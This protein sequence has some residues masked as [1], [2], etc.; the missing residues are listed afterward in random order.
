MSHQRNEQKT[1]SAPKKTGFLIGFAAALIIVVI[2][3]FTVQITVHPP[4][5]TRLVLDRTLE[6]YVAPPCFNQAEVT[7]N[8]VDSTLDTANRLKYK[9][10]SACTEQALQG[11]KKPL[12]DVILETAGLRKSNWKW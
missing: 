4:G 9:A 3:L 12:F 10:D 7:N 1:K 8:L 2:C 6:I 11:I 5:N